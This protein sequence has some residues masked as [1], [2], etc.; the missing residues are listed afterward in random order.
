MTDPTKTPG[1]APHFDTTDVDANRAIEQGLGVGARELAAQ[2]EPGGVTPDPDGGNGGSGSVNAG[3][4]DAL[5]QSVGR[6]AA[7]DED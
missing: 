7:S 6:G 4:G 1:E 3:D 5:N 2:R